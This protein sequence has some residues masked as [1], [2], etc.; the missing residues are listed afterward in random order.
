MKLN[1]FNFTYETRL[2]INWTVEIWQIFI[3]FG[4]NVHGEELD[5]LLF[6][7][8]SLLDNVTLI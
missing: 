2:F 7:L 5:E 6:C 1:V 4:M 8:E 3:A